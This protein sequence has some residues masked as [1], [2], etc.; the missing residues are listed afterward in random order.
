MKGATE[1]EQFVNAGMAAQTAVDELGHGAPAGK[2][3]SR[4]PRVWPLQVTSLCADVMESIAGLDDCRKTGALVATKKE[5]EDMAVDLDQVSRC[6]ATLADNL[7]K[8]GGK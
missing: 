3:E 8:A 5:M 2:T 6:A 1:I 7:R 4:T